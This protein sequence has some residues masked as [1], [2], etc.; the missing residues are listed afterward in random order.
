MPLLHPPRRS[1]VNSQMLRPYAQVVFNPS[2]KP[3]DIESIAKSIEE[4][5]LSST[6][7]GVAADPYSYSLSRANLLL[8]LHS[9]QFYNATLTRMNL[10]KTT[11][12][13][14]EEPSHRA[15]LEGLWTQLMPS[16]RRKAM[17]G[18]SS[19]SI[20]SESWKDIGFQGTEHV[21]NLPAYQRR[22]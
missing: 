17:D 15:M 14:N 3:F 11:A 16:M 18:G 10:L 19:S 12:F 4:I 1:L 20:A 21:P 5:K 6:G 22:I 13:D 9:M 8:C 7:N 2:A